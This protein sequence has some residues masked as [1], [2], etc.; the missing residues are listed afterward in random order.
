[1][2]TGFFPENL[3]LGRNPMRGVCVYTDVPPSKGGVHNLI[4]VL[5][6]SFVHRAVHP[7]LRPPEEICPRA[8]LERS[9]VVNPQSS[10]FARFSLA[11]ADPRFVET[12]FTRLVRD[13]AMPVAR[14]FSTVDQELVAHDGALRTLV[15]LHQKKKLPLEGDTS[16]RGPRRERFQGESN[17][18]CRTITRRQALQ[19]L[20]L[21]RN[22]PL[23]SLEGLPGEAL[24]YLPA[25]DLFG[26]RSYV[27]PE[28]LLLVRDTLRRTIETL[29]TVCHW[30]PQEVD[31]FL[32][33]CEEGDVSLLEW[34]TLRG[35][36]L[37]ARKKRLMRARKLL[38]ERLG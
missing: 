38:R 12:E 1:M 29:C 16:L 36:K 19:W 9:A 37:E 31:E 27:D 11:E 24:E 32:G 20:R 25:H 21:K 30:S 35:E 3:V 15:Y 7:A 18:L 4:A 17:A 23:V 33:I 10:S 2:G 5:S 8:G 13:A 22:Q 34:A 26:N 28:E 14:R 6:T